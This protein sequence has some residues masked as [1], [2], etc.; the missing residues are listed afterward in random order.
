VHS[1]SSEVCIFR[2]KKIPILKFG[3][4]VTVS[5]PCHN[6]T[7]SITFRP[8]VS[9]NKEPKSITFIYKK[10]VF[11]IEHV[12]ITFS[13]LNVSSNQPLK[14]SSKERVIRVKNS[15]PVENRVVARS[16]YFFS[17]HKNDYKC[18][19]DAFW[20]PKMQSPPVVPAGRSLI[21]Q[22]SPR[23]TSQSCKRKRT[24]KKG[25]EKK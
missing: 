2:E 15:T 5:V 10:H 18:C 22:R 9:W 7:V 23:P 20:E 16:G 19:R 24:G 6:A 21:V 17:R 3:R 1:A 8:T 4:G 11:K 25:R 12:T 14:V 13:Q